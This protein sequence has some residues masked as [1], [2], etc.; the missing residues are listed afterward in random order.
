MSL[1]TRSSPT[2]SW[3]AGGGCGVAQG[4]IRRGLDDLL[5]CGQVW[6]AFDPPDVSIRWRSPAALA[7][8]A[9]GEHE[10]ATRLADH[11]V[12]T[13]CSFGAPHALGNALRTAGLI[14]GGESG[15]RLLREAVTVLEGAPALLD[16]AAALTGLGTLEGRLGRVRQAREPLLRGLELAAHCGAAPL[17]AQARAE[18]SLIGL[19]PRRTALSG[20]D[21]LT[22][23]EHRVSQMAAQGQTNR[24]IAQALFLSEKTIENHLTHA[25]A[26]LGIA[27]RRELAKA[28]IRAGGRV[29]VP[30]A[31]Y[32]QAA[33]VDLLATERQHLHA[34]A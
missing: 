1:P 27:S 26:K 33:L 20:R 16:R 24:Q 34:G 12:R 22:A 6:D 14:A 5:A 17:A 9:L 4:E 18:I 21:A 19:R 31:P 2:R 25:Y 7:H 13:A 15:V 29:E 3:P 30:D 11:A 10:Q 8:A 32:G 23:A 28:L